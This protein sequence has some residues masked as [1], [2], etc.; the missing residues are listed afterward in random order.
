MQGRD[1]EQ[2]RLIFLEGIATGNATFEVDAPS[3]DHWNSSHLT[4][5]RLVTRRSDDQ[6]LGWAAL[7]RVSN[8]CVYRGIA[9]VSVY[10]AGSCRRQGVGAALLNALVE[11]SEGAGIWTLQA[12]IFPE[13]QASLRLHERSG[14]RQVGRRERLG[15]MKGAWRDVLLLERRSSV[16]GI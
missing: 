8:R 5:C 4:E 3:W 13:N 1:W 6:V 12:H 7:S 2:V 10:V 11:E 15:E 9:E 16:V 14:F